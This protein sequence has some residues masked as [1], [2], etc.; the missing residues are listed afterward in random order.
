MEIKSLAATGFDTIFEAFSQ[1]FSDY[2]L[3]LDKEELRAMI[4]RRGFDPNL[5][6]AAFS[7]NK[8]VSFTCNGIGDFEGKRMAYDTGTGTLKDYRGKGLATKIFEES[9]PYLR[10]AGIGQYILEV[11]QHNTEAVSVYRKIGFEVTREFYYFRTRT[12]EVKNEVKASNDYFVQET[13]IE[14]YISVPSFWDFH[15]SWQNSFKSIERSPEKF[16]TLGVFSGETLTGYC[17]FEPVAGDV[18][19]IGVD[20]KYRRK[21]IG[22]ML[23]K[24][25]LRLNKNDSIKFINTDIRCTSIT[26]FLKSKNIRP[27]GKQF[28]MIKTI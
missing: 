21:G 24:E 5:S 7:G 4:Q 26:E 6:F 22:S 12:A 9:L 25:M 19:Q 11:L 23:L 10:E 14:K 15:P 13:D 27:T 1:A 28:E 17:I 20:K 18:T 8:I 2:E 3:Q 16:V